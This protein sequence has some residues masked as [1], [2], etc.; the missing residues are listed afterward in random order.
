MA[1]QNRC[2]LKNNPQGGAAKRGAERSRGMGCNPMS[3]GLA[4]PLGRLLS[5]LF[6]SGRSAP[7]LGCYAPQPW[8]RVSLN[9]S[10]S[11]SV[12]VQQL[13]NVRAQ[14]RM[15]ERTQQRRQGWGA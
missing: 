6:V 13:N 14:Q 8:L 11:L 5:T 9:Q 2:S 4:S 10:V 12:C 15:N 7:V 3:N 1:S